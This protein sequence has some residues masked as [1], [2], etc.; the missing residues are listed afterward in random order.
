MLGIKYLFFSCCHKS[1]ILFSAN[2]VS[3]SWTPLYTGRLH[4][5]RQFLPAFLAVRLDLIGP[6]FIYGITPETLHLF[7][8]WRSD[9]SASWATFFKHR[10]YSLPVSAVKY[11][12][13]II[14]VSLPQRLK[15]SC[16]IPITSRIFPAMKST[17]AS[18]D[19]GL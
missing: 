10:I 11:M 2:T 19:F 4:L 17:M 14:G 7:R 13:Y 16:S 9:L 6:H 3:G 5:P 12:T 18:M 8:I 15:I 1:V